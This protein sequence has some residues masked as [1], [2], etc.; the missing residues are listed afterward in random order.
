MK[1]LLGLVGGCAVI[2]VEGEKKGAQHIALWGAGVESES[3]G[4]VGAHYNPLRVIRREIQDP[5]VNGC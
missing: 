3:S 5:L 2:S 4:G 1:E